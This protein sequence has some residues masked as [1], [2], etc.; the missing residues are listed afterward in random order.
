ME[1]ERIY[2][3]K[4][5]IVED[6]AIL[7]ELIA[8]SLERSGFEVIKAQTGESA[9]SQMQE[10]DDYI[11][12]LDYH[13]PDMTGKEL[14]ESKFI[15]KNKVPFIIMTGHGDEKLAVEMMKQN[16][17][18]YVVKDENF[19]DILPIIVQQVVYQVDMEKRLAK[20][21]ESQKDAEKRLMAVN[22]E[23][24]EIIRER[25]EQLAK[26]NEELLRE[27]AERK[28]IE[29]R[30]EDYNKELQLFAE[31]TSELVSDTVENA[32]RMKNLL[33]ELLSY[34][35]LGIDANY[36][37]NTET[38]TALKNALDEVKYLINESSAKITFDQ[39]PNITAD[40][41]QMTILF[42]NLIE[43]CIRSCCNETPKIHISAREDEKEWIFSITS[44]SSFIDTEHKDMVFTIF[45]HLQSCGLSSRSGIW[46]ATC[47]KIVEGHS[48]NIWVESNNGN[49]TIF[50]FSIPKRQIT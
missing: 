5:L 42:R 18:D 48:G 13:L 23:L 33:D 22:E 29:R 17:R 39:L 35:R 20:A 44:N 31:I 16:A 1:D 7:C 3:N 49:E 38:S 21:E 14:I 26:A 10:V 50:C 28:E 25:T 24:E 11:L 6:D 2:T 9:L 32:N 37:Q 4:I 36:F 47:K 41:V 46:L 27:I 40:T 30:F 12:L 8:K 43:N 19:L 15:K 34:S 45:N